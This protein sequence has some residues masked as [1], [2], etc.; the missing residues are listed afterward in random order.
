MSAGRHALVVGGSRGI[1][2]AIVRALL[3][4]PRFDRV[5]AA[6]REPH[7]AEIEA[8]LQTASSRLAIVT[9]DVTDDEA[10]RSWAQ[11]TA[12]QN[13]FPLVFIAAQGLY[14]ARY[15]KTDEP[16]S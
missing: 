5:T 10:S 6:A 4:D 3:A 8:L 15:I 9:L 16:A 13:E 2:L 7:A 12:H 1:G 14:I 11:T